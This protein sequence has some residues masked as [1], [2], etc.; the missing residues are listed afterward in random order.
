MKYILSTVFALT[1]LLPALI[2]DAAT[3]GV[4]EMSNQVDFTFKTKDIV[5]SAATGDVRFSF[6][7]TDIKNPQKIAYWKVRSYCDKGMTVGV[8]ASS[9]DDCGKAVRMNTLPGNSFR[10]WYDNATSDT[11]KFSFKLKAYD[12]NGTWLN[13]ERQAFTWK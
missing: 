12:V 5:R 3:I 10:A 4:I 9:T 13:T 7:V 11:K 8:T 2:A 1:L 6:E